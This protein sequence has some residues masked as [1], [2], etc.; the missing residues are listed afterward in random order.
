MVATP[1]DPRNGI[2]LTALEEKVEIDIAYGGS[3]TGGKKVDMDLYAS[4]VKKARDAGR[5]IAL[6]LGALVAATATTRALWSVPYAGSIDGWATAILFGALAAALFFPLL[7][8]LTP[9]VR[10]ATHPM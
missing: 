4:V 6:V 3:C 2:P 1:G 7:D 9:W 5:R 10:S 8:R